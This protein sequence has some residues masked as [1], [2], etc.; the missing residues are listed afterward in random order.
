MHLGCAILLYRGEGDH[1]SD[2]YVMLAQAWRLRDGY[3][4]QLYCYISRRSTFRPLRNNKVTSTWKATC[5]ESS[6]EAGHACA[7]MFATIIA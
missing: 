4:V 1:K 5:L 6:Q 3:G 2:S 7:Y